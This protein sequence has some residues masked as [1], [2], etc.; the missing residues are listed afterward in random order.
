MVYVVPPFEIHPSHR[1]SSARLRLPLNSVF[2]CLLLSLPKRQDPTQGRPGTGCAECLM[3]P[4]R[5]PNMALKR[6]TAGRQDCP[7]P[8][9]GPQWRRRQ[10]RRCAPMSWSGT[11]H[12]GLTVPGTPVY[13]ILI[14]LEA[15]SGLL[16]HDSALAGLI[17]QR[18]RFKKLLMST[19]QTLQKIR[20][21]AQHQAPESVFGTTSVKR[22]A[23]TQNLS[24]I[25]LAWGYQP[26]PHYPH[27]HLYHFTVPL[28]LAIV[29]GFLGETI[30]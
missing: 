14:R 29:F 7:S 27:P 30:K 25:A 26:H 13:P 12:E 15:V 18:K 1:V 10:Q 9:G 8:T 2:G 17:A 11:G 19:K 24:W 21:E 16:L 6:P 23:H 20:C 5:T 3:P 28:V 4:Q 22:S